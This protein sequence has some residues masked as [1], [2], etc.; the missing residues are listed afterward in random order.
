LTFNPKTALFPTKTA[1]LNSSKFSGEQIAFLDGQKG[2][3]VF[4]SIA[5]TVN[6]NFG[7]LPYMNYANTQYGS[8]V[9]AAVTAKT[10]LYTAFGAWQK[11]LVAYGKQQGFTVKTS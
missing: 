5:K 7:Y 10:D 11:L 3:Q 6:P 9:G 2:N 1:V 4:A 8:T